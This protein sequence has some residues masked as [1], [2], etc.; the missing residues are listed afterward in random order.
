MLFNSYS[1]IFFFLPITY[2]LYSWLEKFSNQ[3]VKLIWLVLASLFFYGW[4][5]PVY[6]I[7]I[8]S[9]ILFN[10]F[11]GN[12]LHQYSS[13][14]LLIFGISVNLG[15]L[16]YFKYANFFVDTVNLISGTYYYFEQ[17]LL[18]LA[19]SFF[20]FQQIAYLV[21]V[22][23]KEV[24]EHDFLQYSL[25]VLFFPQLIAGP[26]VHHREMLPQFLKKDNS[27]KSEN[28]GIGISVFIIG[29]FKKVVIADGI[30]IYATPVF[31]AA[32]GGVSLT[33]FEA[34]GGAL[35]YTLQLY[36]DFSGYSDMA[37]GL[38]RMFG[39]KLPE[40]FNSPYKAN[41]IIDFWRCWHMTLSRFLRDYL[42]FPLGGNRKG[43]TRRYVNLMLT[44]LLGGL[45][46][47]AGWTFIIWGGLH[48]FY[49]ITN[50][51][52]HYLKRNTILSHLTLIKAD[53]YIISLFSKVISRLLTFLAIVIAWVF[54]R[55]ET[56]DGAL[57]ILYGMSGSNGLVL[58]EKL[59]SKIP[60][61][62]GI[63]QFSGEKIGSF[64]H[65]KGLTLI[66]V[67]LIIV[68]YIP[69]TK[70][71][72]NMGKTS[73]LIQLFAHVY[74][75]IIGIMGAVAVTYMNDVSEFLYFNF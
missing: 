5:N 3:R 50:H 47:G 34:W 54:F 29:L 72:V 17:I 18:P 13:R 32:D 58:P 7:L 36:F 44:M 25:F 63:I 57:K 41:N 53:N 64:G 10:Y 33:F 20:T 67:L 74:A 71:W 73:P 21:D 70:S 12:L 1:F 56:F 24:D 62:F 22:Y 26:I 23:R 59:S 11:W 61:L 39:I 9:S 4:W 40:N 66:I 46:H 45:W 31:T 37:I 28:L 8:V 19:I 43:R 15:L 16:G 49:L 51:V 48:G 65:H 30:A 68:W 42:Y 55:A 27:V 14:I 75:I 69:N 35:A 6:V 2:L 60:D 52:W 38:A